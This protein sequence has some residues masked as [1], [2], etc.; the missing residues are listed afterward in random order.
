MN[1]IIQRASIN[2]IYICRKTNPSI[3]INDKDKVS[4]NII[5]NVILQSDIKKDGT[6]VPMLEVKHCIW[7]RSLY[8]PSDKS[9]LTW[10]N[11]S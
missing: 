9:V 2:V 6:K 8:L 10:N 4:A 1:K 7:T 3:H 11:P 5:F